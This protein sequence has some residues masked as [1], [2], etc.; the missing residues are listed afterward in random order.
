MHD[1]DSGIRATAVAALAD[2]A[3][4][5]T[6]YMRIALNDS[7]NEVRALAVRTMPAA[8]L[9]GESLSSAKQPAAV[10]AEALR[11]AQPAR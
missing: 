7:S 3:D 6:D 1:A 4:G 2:V 9:V 5:T 10:R 8:K 11:R